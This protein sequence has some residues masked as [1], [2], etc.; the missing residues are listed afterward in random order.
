MRLAPLFAPIALL[1]MAGAAPA[2]TLRPGD[3]LAYSYGP[4]APKIYRI[5][6]VSGIGEP[7]PTLE[8]LHDVTGLSVAPNGEIL[9]TQVVLNLPRRIAA[10]DPETGAVRTV[11]EFSNGDPDQLLFVPQDVMATPDG[12]IFASGAYP[13]PP[14]SSNT[15]N[16]IFEIDPL[17]GVQRLL[18]GSD[19]LRDLEARWRGG[20][21]L[22]LEPEGTVVFFG[23]WREEIP[24]TSTT[25]GFANAILRVDPQTGEVSL[26]KLLGPGLFPDTILLESEESYLALFSGS[27]LGPGTIARISRSDGSVETLVTADR[28]PWGTGMVLLPDGDVAVGN[29]DGIERIDL[30]TGARSFLFRKPFFTETFVDLVLV[31]V[32]EP[33]SGLLLAGGLLALAAAARGSA[34]GAVRRGLRPL[35]SGPSSAAPSRSPRGRA[36]GSTRRGRSRRARDPRRAP[37]PGRAARAFARRS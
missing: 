11:S 36:H 3:L 15:A 29:S 12:R 37:R 18:N 17:T 16:G 24:A 33:G 22:L 8:P 1:A 13:P 30:E 7:I 9:F 5:D 2:L 10:L 34:R 6:P 19:W 21:S 4:N 31:P 27:F 14:G 20:D 23:A 26:E 25:A 28:N 32:P 35:R